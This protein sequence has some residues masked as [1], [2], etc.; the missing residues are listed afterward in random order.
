MRIAQIVLEGASEFERKCQRVDFA[1][2]S[3]KHDVIVTDG[4]VVSADVA[5]VYGPSPLPSRPLVGFK[6]PYVASSAPASRF[7]LSRPARPGIIVSPIEVAGSDGQLLP[8]AVEEIWF[9]APAKRES[10]PPRNLIASYSRASIINAVEQALLR[11]GRFREDIA[12][13]LFDRIP[14]PDDLAGVDAWIDPAVNQNDHDGFVAEAIA[15]GKVVV[16]SRIP[17]NAH[18]LENGRTGFLV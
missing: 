3:A 6:I 2:L 4:P 13:N 8:E 15:A 1:A 14:T 11:I 5:H 9:D 12:W 16:A 7:S 10:T 18:R 17:I